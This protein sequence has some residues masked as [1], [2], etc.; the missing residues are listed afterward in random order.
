[1]VGIRIIAAQSAKRFPRKLF[2]LSDMPGIVKTTQAA[3]G[4]FLV[5]MFEFLV[6]GANSK[7]KTQN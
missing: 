4:Q 7:L 2:F 1:M 6:A 3:R 5:L